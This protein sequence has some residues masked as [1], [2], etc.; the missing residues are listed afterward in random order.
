MC[1]Q[2]DRG[3]SIHEFDAG[4]DCNGTTYQVFRVIAFVCMLMYP[5]GIPIGF[6]VLL[7]LNRKVLSRDHRNDIDFKKFVGL[8]RF[9]APETDEL[10]GLEDLEEK[11]NKIDAD[12]SGIITN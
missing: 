11:F 7:Y 3:E 12:S 5:F 1:R 9:Y 4:L 10:P 8:A 6:G 2:L